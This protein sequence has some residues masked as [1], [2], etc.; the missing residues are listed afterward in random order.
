MRQKIGSTDNNAPEVVP[1]LVQKRN[2]GR[3][4]EEV[5]GL[6]S[7]LRSRGHFIM[8]EKRIIFPF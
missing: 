1:L 5:Y 4:G 3:Y 8:R 7:I 2:D 6:E